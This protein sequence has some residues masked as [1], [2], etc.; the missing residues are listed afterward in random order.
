MVRTKMHASRAHP[1][2]L[3]D[4]GAFVACERQDPELTVDQCQPLS[5]PHGVVVCHGRILRQAGGV[6]SVSRR[7]KE[8]PKQY[9]PLTAATW[10]S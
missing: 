1:R 10:R 5:R 7:G 3:E 4:H 8:E 9:G 2:R 6:G